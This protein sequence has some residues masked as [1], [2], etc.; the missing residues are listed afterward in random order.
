MPAKLEPWG[1]SGLLKQGTYQVVLHLLQLIEGGQSLKRVPLFVLLI[2]RSYGVVD[3]Y[4]ILS[5][6]KPIDICS[7]C[8]LLSYVR[9]KDRGK[10]GQP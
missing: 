1:C 7:T 10:Q 5:S 9:M 2:C 8:I 6:S 4:I 3:V